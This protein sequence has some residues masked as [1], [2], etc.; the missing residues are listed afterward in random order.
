MTTHKLTELIRNDRSHGATELALIALGGIASLEIEPSE[1]TRLIET[2]KAARPSMSALQVLLTRLELRLGQQPVA[3]ACGELIEEVRAARRQ[4]AAHMA[5]LIDP[6]DV[7]MTHSLS[8]TVKEV[9]IGLSRA[10]FAGRIIVTESRPGDEGKLLVAFLLRWK[11]SVTYITEAQINLLMPETDKVLFGAD[12]VLADG[13]IINK[14][15][16]SLMALSAVY[17]QV[18]VYVCAEEFKQLDRQDCELEQMD[19]AELGL[20]LEGVDVRNT[21]FERIPSALITRWV[22]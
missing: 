16:S 3:I 6:G 22:R 18:P 10:N 20:S 17:H 14:V 7:L 9:F 12:T 11:L 2:L 13:S 1:L 4:A 21:W 8:S 15:G 19:P 5:A